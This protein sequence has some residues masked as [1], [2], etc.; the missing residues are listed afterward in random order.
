MRRWV[1]AFLVVVHHQVVCGETHGQQVVGDEAVEQVVLVGVVLVALCVGIDVL[2]V[3]VLHHVIHCDVECIL[4]EEHAPEAVGLGEEGV[5]VVAVLGCAEAWLGNL[6]GALHVDGH[7]GFRYLA[8]QEF[9]FVGVVHVFLER[10]AQADG[11]YE[12]RRDVESATLLLDGGVDEVAHGVVAGCDDAVHGVYDAVEHEDVSVALIDG[13]V[14]Y[15]QRVHVAAAVGAM[16]G[17]LAVVHVGDG[18]L[19]ILTDGEVVG[20]VDSVVA[21]VDDAVVDNHL[22]EGVAHVLVGESVP[23]GL[24]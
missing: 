6:G 24:G 4:A 19:G 17:E 12:Q 11:F 18:Q 21:A 7:D 3:E 16:Y 5:A 13:C 9:L 10:V 14:A 23:R 22:L 1:V 15:E 20:I 8:L 2:C